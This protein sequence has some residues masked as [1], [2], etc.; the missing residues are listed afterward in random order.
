[1]RFK[2][3]S[4]LIKSQEKVRVWVIG[5]VDTTSPQSCPKTLMVPSTVEI[6]Y[7]ND[8]VN[9]LRHVAKDAFRQYDPIRVR[10]FH[11]YHIIPRISD[12]IYFNFINFSV[13]FNVM[14]CFGVFRYQTSFSI[15]S[16]CFIKQH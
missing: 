3:V 9:L 15:S 6:Q 5:S 2:D 13:Y 14:N 4:R 1:M 11:R 12:D 7:L 10:A 16:I 8:S